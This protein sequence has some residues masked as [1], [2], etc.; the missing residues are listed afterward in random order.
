MF[1]LTDFY[2]CF[3]SGNYKVQKWDIHKQG[4]LDSAPGL[5]MF[6]TVTTPTTEVNILYECFCVIHVLTSDTGRQSYE[7]Y[8]CFG[9]KV[10]P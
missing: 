10:N 1:Y 3:Y 2:L 7:K 9:E 4:F 8:G 6:V 5:G